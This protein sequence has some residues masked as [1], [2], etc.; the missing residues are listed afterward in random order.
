MTEQNYRIALLIDSENISPKYIKNIFDELSK[1]G[2]VTTKRVYG[3]WS[4]DGRKSWKAL[5]AENALSAVQQFQNTSK[6][7]SSDSAL[8]IDAMD[9]LYSNHADSFCIVSSDGDFTRLIT[10]IRE[11]GKF[12]IG[13]GEKKSPKALINACDKFIYLDVAQEKPVVEAEP[14]KKPAKSVSKEKETAPEK[15]V[16]V[17]PVK[18]PETDLKASIGEEKMDMLRKTVDELTNDE[19]DEWATLADVGNRMCKLFPDFEAKNYGFKKLSDLIKAIGVFEI[20]MEISPTD[21]NSKVYS[22]KNR[23]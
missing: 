20:R 13:M 3:D 15:E 4:Q 5:I 7:N 2:V 8:I 1:Y 6:K 11:D 19:D 16:A 17:A 9:I 12:V 14:V 21:D 10:R 23:K 18:S 22:I